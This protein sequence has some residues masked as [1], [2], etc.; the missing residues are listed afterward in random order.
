MEV[1][2]WWVGR[3]VGIESIAHKTAFGKTDR[4]TLAGAVRHRAGGSLS[5][6]YERDD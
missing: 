1:G 2:S 6:F 4:A 3:Q 5:S